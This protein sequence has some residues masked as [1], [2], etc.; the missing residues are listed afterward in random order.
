MK[1]KQSQ[2]ETRR[3]EAKTR[4]RTAPIPSR[5]L[6]SGEAKGIFEELRG[7][8]K[9]P[10]NTPIELFPFPQKREWVERALAAVDTYPILSRVVDNTLFNISLLGLCCGLKPNCNP[11][12]QEED[13]F[14]MESLKRLIAK[15]PHA[16][17]WGI[18]HEGDLLTYLARSRSHFIILPWIVENYPWVFD[19]PGYHDKVLEPPLKHVLDHWARRTEAFSVSLIKGLFESYPS[20]MSQIFRNEDEPEQLEESSFSLILENNRSGVPYPERFDLVEFMLRNR[21]ELVSAHVLGVPSFSYVYFSS[22]REMPPEESLYFL[23]IFKLIMELHPASARLPGP[24]GS[25]FPID[26]LADLFSGGSHELKMIIAITR[27]MYPNIPK[28]TAK[29]PVVQKVLGILDKEKDLALESI[30]LKQVKLILTKGSSGSKVSNTQQDIYD[31]WAN[32]RLTKIN[33]QAKQY[34]EKDLP[35]LKEGWPWETEAG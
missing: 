17:L 9:D 15:N 26:Y 5:E 34:R 11:P 19:Q 20:L 35:A 30:R 12:D 10:S 14:L 33:G 3:S 7:F 8:F 21:P 25:P 1:R 16:L 28:E 4:S 18:E 32:S 2:P 31:C 27:F 22:R 23:K 29:K 6:D 24:N 13:Q